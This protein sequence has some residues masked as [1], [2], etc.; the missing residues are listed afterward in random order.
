[1]P[2]GLGMLYRV[3]RIPI[4]A[5]GQ[6]LS[7]FSRAESRLGFIFGWDFVVVVF[8]VAVLSSHEVI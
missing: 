5:G 6:V 3:G 2:G 4:K 8:F 1:M 7:G